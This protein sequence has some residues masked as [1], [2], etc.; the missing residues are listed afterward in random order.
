MLEHSFCVQFSLILYA[1][2][3]VRFVVQCA[4]G[5]GMRKVITVI[6]GMLCVNT[7]FAYY[8]TGQGRWISRDPVEENDSKNVYSFIYNNSICHWDFMGLE[9]RTE[10]VD[11]CKIVIYVGHGPSGSDSESVDDFIS[12]SGDFDHTLPGEVNVP[13][14][15]S[16]ATLVGCNSE[17]IPVNGNAIDGYDRMNG[18]FLQDA[19]GPQINLALIA[20]RKMANTIC[21][22]TKS[23]CESVTIRVDIPDGFADELRKRQ[24]FY[25]KFSWIFGD[26]ILA[27][28]ANMGISFINYS[29]TV[30]CDEK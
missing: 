13:Y 23:C 15:C 19:T 25:E 22:S 29:E 28:G 8:Q 4:K 17:S 30:Q 2:S 27:Y 26:G 1:L 11:K 10:T 12:R 7:A 5:K 16:G 21:S 24:E 3:V 20:A 18:S 14:S 9:T 6:F